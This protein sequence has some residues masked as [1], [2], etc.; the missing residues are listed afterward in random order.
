MHRLL[1]RQLQRVFGKDFDIF[2]LP[3]ET[4]Q[5]IEKI[6]ESYEENSRERKLLENTLE[7]SSKELNELNQQL[8]Q[9][10]GKLEEEVLRR[11]ADL[12]ES[13]SRYRELLD[14]MSSGAAMYTT[15]ANDNSFICID[16]N[17]AGTRIL[18]QPQGSILGSHTNKNHFHTIKENELLDAFRR[19]WNSGRREHISLSQCAS[20]KKLLYWLEVDIYKLNSGEIVAI[21]NDITATKQA[22][23]ESK[24]LQRQLQQSQKMDTIGH[25]TGGI[26]HDFN[27]ILASVLGYTE[28]A[29]LEYND[30]DTLNDY[31]QQIY[32]AGQR[33][34]DLIKQMLAFSRGEEGEFSDIS[35]KGMVEETIKML[36]PTLP[37]SI[38][39]ELRLDNNLATIHGDKTML[40][41]VI[42]NMCVNARDA[43]NSQG[44]INI[45]LTPYTTQDSTCNSC[46]CG[47]SGEFICLTISDNGSGIKPEKQ[48]NIFE[49]FFSTK[50]VG[51]GTGMGL[52]MV[53][54]IMHQHDGH[55]LL[56]STPG[57]GTEFKLLF[58]A[59]K[60]NSI[61]ATGHFPTT[62]SL[63]HDFHMYH[64]MIIDDDEA[65]A[66]LLGKLVSKHGLKTT[67]F[68]DSIAAM[69]AFKTKPKEF[70]LV[71]SDQ[72]MPN[73]TGDELAQKFLEI[74]PELPM[75]ICT[76]YSETINEERAKKLGLKALLKKPIDTEE[77]HRLLNSTLK[78]IVTKQGNQSS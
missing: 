77:L 41:Q 71:I 32:T 7:I 19:V 59:S 44:K 35:L 12:K 39:I 22:E 65:V 13:E 76:G 56:N 46:H 58:P 31:L 11:T 36:R 27:N 6:S 45:C 34:R 60:P 21:Y 28:M 17:P 68:T 4:Q 73:I 8:L 50:P 72:T 74:R 54:G 26:A 29:M 42:M 69:Q 33:A 38:S 62:S 10:K 64:A 48:A 40:S 67:V 57:Q 30:D 18:G 5:L 3:D 53:H 20:K 61:T 23:L 49:P 25:L 63:S 70:D 51:K 37:S 55:I 66:T 1:N 15:T 47:F 24:L 2:S 43:F 52:A 14:N 9:Q 78:M 16:Q 75:V